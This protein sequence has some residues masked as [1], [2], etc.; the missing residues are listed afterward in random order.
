MTNE[1]PRQGQIRFIGTLKAGIRRGRCLSAI[2]LCPTS[3]ALF[4]E[5]GFAGRNDLIRVHAI[6]FVSLR[7]GFLFHGR[8]LAFFR[9]KDLRSLD[10]LHALAAVLLIIQ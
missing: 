7:D 3:I 9:L 8:I 6:D 1:L 2:V 5:V 10:P 4:I